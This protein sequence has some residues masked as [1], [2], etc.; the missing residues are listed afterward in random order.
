MFVKMIPPLPIFV[1]TEK[2]ALHIIA[3]KSKWLIINANLTDENNSK[4]YGSS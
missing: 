1:R 4:R 3:K 2:L